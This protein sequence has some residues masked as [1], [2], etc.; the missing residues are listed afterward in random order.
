M[1]DFTGVNP[2]DRGSNDADATEYERDSA[3]R[4]DPWTLSRTGLDLHTLAASESLYSLANG[5]IGLRGSL[6]EGE[7]RAVPGTY[8]NGFFEE[9]PLPHAE[10]GYGFPESGETAV[11]VT[12]GKIIRLFVGDSPFD[13]RYG[14]IEHHERAL[15]LRA[16]TLDR[17]TEWT[18]PS[19]T[20]VRV[21]SRRLVSFA[22]RSLAAICYD[23]EPLDGDAYVALQSDL[24]ANESGSTP[25]SDP[26]DAAHLDRPLRAEFAAAR[27]SRAVLVHRTRRSK[28]RVAAGMTHLLEVP[29]EVETTIEAAGDLARY[30]VTA[31]VPRGSRLRLIKL[32]AYGWSHRRSAPA[33]RDQV[34]AALSVARLTGW[35][36]LIEQQRNFLDEFWSRA[37]VEIDGD[38]AL[39]QAVRVSMFH[40]LQSAARAEGQAISAKGLSGVGYDGHTFWDAEVFA[41][42]MLTYTMPA[43][44][45]DHLVW[46]HATLG[47]ARARAKELG[48][49][50]AA[51][52]WRTISGKENSGYWPAGTAA[53]HVNSAVAAATARYLAVTGDE[54]F[55][56]VAGV[57]LLT[58]TARLWASIGHFNDTEFHID[59][60][61]GPDEYTAIVDDNLYTNVMA[62]QN[63]T[64][65]ADAC[66]RRPEV[67]ATL[68]VDADEIALWRRAAAGVAMP[69]NDDLG[70]HEQSLGFTRHAE[71][72]FAATKKKFYPLLLHYPY[73]QLYRRQVIKQA[74]LTLAMH[75]RGDLFTPE[76][77]ERNFAYYEARTV[78]DSSLSAAT[79]AVLAAETGHLE[80]AYDYWAE[81]A[82]VDLGDLHGNVDDGLHIAAMG[83]SWMVAVAGFGGMR[84]HGGR[85][86]FAPRLPRALQR[87]A[88]QLT[89][90]GNV[91]RVSIR[92]DGDT[93]AEEATYEVEAGPGLR[94]W[95]HGEPVDVRPDQPVTLPVPVASDV[96][97]VQQPARRAP[98]RRHSNGR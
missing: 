89:Y 28:L 3:Y 86:T 68:G 79:Q 53:F 34:E 21:T 13:M 7:P 27:D 2:A 25:S 62:A 9:R 87:I 69:Y 5:H 49:R 59:G 50:G 52:P 42:P 11:N 93:G 48:L 73:F 17:H 63:L 80:L 71:W 64:D 67:A 24:L 91:L 37:D 77:K 43:A 84:D 95:H 57:E 76:Q 81:V 90:G 12:D 6:E 54:D 55:E 92:R 31:K 97:P 19:G 16:G 33:L 36:G 18:S 8:V 61:T 78:R 96:E 22:Q 83:G 15:D 14:S 39:Q 60:V 29:D 10:S 38:P 88:F 26:R 44:A 82:F 70:V 72:D 85:V 4:V 35:D 46:R 98:K 74:D 56:T 20:P 45:R 41:L 40:I 32:V 23:V 47:E 94:T 66:E 58:E 75:L 1:T 51:F 65:A 30:T